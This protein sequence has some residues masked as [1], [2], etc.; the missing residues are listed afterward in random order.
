VKCA[1]LEGMKRALVILVAIGLGT[2]FLAATS[3]GQE[4]ST[5]KT[6]KTVSSSAG[7]MRISSD[8][9]TTSS[10]A[11]PLLIPSVA[12]AYTVPL[13]PP[14][15]LE[16]ATLV[17]I[18][19]FR[20]AHSLHLVKWSPRLRQAA[21][22]HTNEMAAKGYFDH[23]SYKGGPNSWWKRINTYYP[24]GNF[25]DWVVG[26]NLIWS[27]ADLAPADI[28]A[29]WEASPKHLSVLMDPSWREAGV[30]SLRTHGKGIYS[31]YPQ[32]TILTADFGSRY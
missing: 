27:S 18:N 6:A 29:S 24:Q 3:Q 17:A 26:E 1:T 32:V 22:S 31:S 21:T 10:F 5:Q 30:S 2:W 25:G 13:T 9:A 12:S 28:M 4:G 7:P 16:Q 19:Q 8:T 20:K 14:S 15:A 23:S 11:A